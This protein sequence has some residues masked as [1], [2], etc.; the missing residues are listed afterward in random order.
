MRGVYYRYNAETDNF[1]R[2]YPTIWGRLRSVFMLILGCGV[3]SIVVYVLCYRSFGTPAERQLR[4]EN[5]KLK[6]EYGMLKRRVDQAVQVLRKIED[7]DRKLYRV[8]L[9]NDSIVY[10]PIFVSYQSDVR[11]NELQDINVPTIVTLFNSDVEL[12]EQRLYE[13]IRSFEELNEQVRTMDKELAYIPS[14][15]PLE[16]RYAEVSATFGV[17]SDLDHSGVKSHEG[18]DFIAPVGVPVYATAQGKVISIDKKA[19]GFNVSI[20]HGSNYASFYSHLGEIIVNQD[21]DISR[22]EVIGFIGESGLHYEVKY[23]NQPENPLN[24]FYLDFTPEEYE[25]YLRNAENAVKLMD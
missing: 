24:Y 20:Q 3:V 19:G 10:R 2:I 9:Q 17:N 15:L 14:M 11:R 13:Q 6:R 25:D 7:R 1:E 5:L 23:K 4:E 21:Q 8:L 18:I 12:L 22:G 16:R